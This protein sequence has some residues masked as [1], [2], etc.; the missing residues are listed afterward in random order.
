MELKEIQP[1]T[2][3]AQSFEIPEGYQVMDMPKM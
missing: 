3:N 2:P 1:W